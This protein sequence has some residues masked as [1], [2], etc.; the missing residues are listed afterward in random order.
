ELSRIKTQM[1]TVINNKDSRM[2][3]ELTKELSGLIFNLFESEHGVA[4]YI[5]ILQNFNDDFNSQ[6]WTD[7]SKARSILNKG[8][9][10]AASNPS[11]ERIVSYCRELWQLLPNPKGSSRDDILGN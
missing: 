4:L 1:E 9:A 7:K 11:K 5:A 8:L 2:A 6:P 10:E 3:S